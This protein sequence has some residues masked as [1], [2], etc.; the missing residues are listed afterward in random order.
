MARMTVAF[1]GANLG[2][3]EIVLVLAV[4]LML[5]GSDRLPGMARKLGRMMEELR[6]AARDVSKEILRPPDSPPAKRN[7]TGAG[8]GEDRG[9]A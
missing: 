8:K 6:R 1:L 4:I 9:G 2:A 5:F 7:G 3:G